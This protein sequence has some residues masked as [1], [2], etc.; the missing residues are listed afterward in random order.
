MVAADKVGVSRDVELAR[1]R[2][3]RDLTCHARGGVA[4]RAEWVPE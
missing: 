4:L 2:S 1:L 3:D